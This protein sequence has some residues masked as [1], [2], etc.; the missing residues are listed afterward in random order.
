MNLNLSLSAMPEALHLGFMSRGT[1]LV[2]KQTPLKSLE[3]EQLQ[4]LM[5]AARGARFF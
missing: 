4:K 3:K 1:Q 5:V 2:A